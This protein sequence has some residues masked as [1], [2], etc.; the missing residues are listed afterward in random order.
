MSVSN[1]FVKTAGRLDENLTSLRI[2]L[3]MKSMGTDRVT[4]KI[5]RPLY[6]KIKIVIEGSGFSSVNEF[7]VYILRDLL[8]V[9]GTS[10]KDL[11]SQEVDAIRKRLENLG[12]F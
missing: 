12:Y 11:S 10:K 7:V 3:K 2:V 8:S 4:L 5:P 6:E 9:T 1:R